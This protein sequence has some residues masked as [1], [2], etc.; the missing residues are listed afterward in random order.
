[1]NT[2]LHRNYRASESWRTFFW[3][4]HTLQDKRPWGASETLLL[5]MLD[6]SKRGQLCRKGAYSEADLLAVAQR[7]YNDPLLQFRVP[8]QRNGILIIIGP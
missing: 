5:R 2:L 4:D 8:G 1:M 3:F 7:L 6:I